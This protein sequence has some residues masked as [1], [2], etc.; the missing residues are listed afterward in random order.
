MRRTRG[1]RTRT[2]EVVSSF[3]RPAD[4]A[5]CLLVPTTRPPRFLRALW[6]GMGGWV[7]S[8]LSHCHKRSGEKSTNQ[9]LLRI[10]FICVVTERQNRQNVPTRPETTHLTLLARQ[11]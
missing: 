10:A 4:N 7:L 8:I 1:T 11:N 9:P 6:T 2:H 5:P 3:T